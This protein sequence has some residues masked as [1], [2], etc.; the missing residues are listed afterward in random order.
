M[1]KLVLVDFNDLYVIAVG[2]S[3]A[4]IVISRKNDK[5]DEQS[6][7]RFLSNITDFFQSLILYSKT[8]RLQKEE[9]VI[10]KIEYYLKTNKLKD[11]TKGALGLVCQKA[12]E[13]QER[14]NN[15]EKWFKERLH[16][17]T[18]T[19]YL[20]VVSCDCSI[21]GL[22]I[23]YIGA[24]ANK[25][26][27][28]Y[29]GFVGWLLIFVCFGVVHCLIYERIPIKNDFIRI[30][31]PNIFLH[32]II[33]VIFLLVGVKYCGGSI[34]PISSDNLPIWSV[35][36][37]FIGFIIYLVFTITANVV[38]FFIMLIRILCLKINVNVEQ[39]KDDIERYK[40]ELDSIDNAIKIEKL[41]DKFALTGGNAAT[42]S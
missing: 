18:K 12:K 8:K 40:D 30:T 25:T 20:N 2:I 16:L 29:S 37:C 35:F 24:L 13:V 11:E 3:M 15:L 21:F 23:L 4:Y 6:F 14:A 33:A 41:G 1:N 34:L 9:F 17:F 27:T 42:T 7:F 28:D 38:F 26:Q 36:A 31:R 39:Q 5:S 22:I 32:S 10:T 19:D